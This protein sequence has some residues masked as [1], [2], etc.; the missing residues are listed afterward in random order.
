MHGADHEQVI[1]V[2]DERKILAVAA[3]DLGACPQPERHEAVAV[4]GR[5]LQL[6]DF[7]V[8]REAEILE[9]R[10]YPEQD[11][12]AMDRGFPTMVDSLSIAW[13]ALR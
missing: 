12:P 6:D 5:G 10:G 9:C 2:E 7:V 1:R 13:S 11:Q 3:L 8:G 4:V